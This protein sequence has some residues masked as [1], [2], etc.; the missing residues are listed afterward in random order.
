MSCPLGVKR[1]GYCKNAQGEEDRSASSYDISQLNELNIFLCLWPRRL[2][3]NTM[4]DASLVGLS[5]G[6]RVGDT[7]ISKQRTSQAVA[8]KHKRFKARADV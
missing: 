4:H 8:Q 6:I 1:A 7:R 2:L 3:I 5:L